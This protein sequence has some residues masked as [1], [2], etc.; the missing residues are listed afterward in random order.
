MRRGDAAESGVESFDF[1]IVGAGSAGCVLANRLS[2]DPRNRV[3]LLEFGGSDGSVLIQM[4]SALSIPMNMPKY[5]WAYETEPEPGLGGRRMHCPR[6]KVLGGS[7]SING[8]VYIRGQREDFDD[9]GVPGW[10]FD[11]LLPCFL[12]SED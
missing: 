7:S 6:G 4:P 8:L 5:N 2:E 10:G 3:L 1:I 11:D 12:R 9:W